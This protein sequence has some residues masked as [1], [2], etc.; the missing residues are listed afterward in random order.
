MIQNLKTRTK[1]G[2][3]TFQQCGPQTIQPLGFIA[4]NLPSQKNYPIHE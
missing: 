2:R 4:P 3:I 1:H